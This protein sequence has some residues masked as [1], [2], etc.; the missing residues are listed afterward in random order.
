MFTGNE[1]DRLNDEDLQRT[2]DLMGI[3]FAENEA[4]SNLGNLEFVK[5]VESVV[6]VIDRAVAYGSPARAPFAERLLAGNRAVSPSMRLVSVTLAPHSR[7]S[8]SQTGPSQ[9]QAL[10]A[11]MGSE[12]LQLSCTCTF[13]KPVRPSE[14]PGSRRFF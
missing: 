2:C 7:S 13:K 5:P 9:L 6:G 4:E 8:R 12:T 11:C 10:M 14:K 3:S 1:V